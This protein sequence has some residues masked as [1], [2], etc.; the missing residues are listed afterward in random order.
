MVLPLAVTPMPQEPEKSESVRVLVMGDSMS[1]YSDRTES[2]YPS[3]DVNKEDL[4]WHS[5]LGAKLPW[6]VKSY[7]VIALDGVGYT[8]SLKGPLT[9]WAMDHFVGQTPPDVILLALGMDDP[10]DDAGAI[11][12]GLAA[13]LEDL[14]QLW[15]EARVILVIPPEGD[16]RGEEKQAFKAA[17]DSATETARGLDLRVIDLRDSVVSKYPNLYTLDG[18]HPNAAGMTAIANYIANQFR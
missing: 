1:D 15:P 13:T 9:F 6:D 18:R 11:N 8:Q 10:L 14:R 7:E 2:F 16:F 5:I 17:W 4:M 3:G 12:D